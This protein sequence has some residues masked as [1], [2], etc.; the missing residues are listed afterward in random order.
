MFNGVFTALVTPFR[1][2]LSV[3]EQSLRN[4]VDRQ[5]D[6]G[7]DGLVP[8]GTTGESPTVSHEENLEVIRVVIDQA[9][10]RV[11]VIAGTGSNS[12]DEALNMTLK[13]KKL[14]ASASLQVTPYYNKPNQEGLFR[15]FTAIAD[16]SPVIVY[17]IPGRSARNIETPTLMRMARHEQIV[18]VKEASGD[19]NQVM[20]V[21]MQ[22]PAGFKLL[23]GVD[24]LTFPMMA[25]GG[26]GA[27]SV[28][29][30]IVPEV[31]KLMIQQPDKRGRDRHFELLPLV[32]ALFLD[33]NP[34]PVKYAMSLMGLCRNTYRLPLCEPS[35]P[36]KEAVRNVLKTMGLI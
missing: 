17:N 29:S 14:G 10:G 22:R 33:T 12:T 25:L 3:D 32:K 24:E 4:L 7:V 28:L 9:K 26:D 21:L 35:D 16:E 1:D 27:I 11:P 2:D 15:H 36:V 23:S 6:A 19:M 18:A 8:M 34:I 5:I 31:V 30:N 13:A 20:D